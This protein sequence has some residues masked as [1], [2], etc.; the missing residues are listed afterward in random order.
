MVE[1]RTFNPWVAGSSPAGGTL[2]V[3]IENGVEQMKKAMTIILLSSVVV[4]CGTRTVVVEQ[5][6]APTN[7]PITVPPVADKEQNFL[8]GMTS[9]WPADVSRLGKTAI[10]DMGRLACGA[11]DE[12]ATV[13]DFAAMAER[14]N[15]DGGFIG[16]LIREA[17]ENFCPENQWFIDSALNA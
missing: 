3:F 9:D 17:V 16:S 15:V 6:P 2:K 5:Q 1:Q 12:G 14:S 10:I 11:I 4:G 13:S 8:D 7:P